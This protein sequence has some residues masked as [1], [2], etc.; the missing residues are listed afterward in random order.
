VSTFSSI[1]TIRH[2]MRRLVAINAS[3]VGT[4]PTGLGV[5]AIQLTRAL[6][7]I[8]DD[9]AVITSDPEPFS[10]LRARIIGIPKFV[11]PE[12]G[13]RGHLARITFAQTLWSFIA[14]ARHLA[15][16]VHTVPEAALWTR[17]PQ[18]TMIHDVLPL[19]F[20]SEYPRQQHYFRYLVPRALSASHAVAALSHT[21]RDA[22]MK[23]FG[24]AAGKISVV[25]P[26]YD[27]AAFYPDPASRNHDP[28]VL[29]VGNLLPHKN[30]LRLVD[31]FAILLR[32]MSCR[33]VIRGDGRPAHLAA[34]VERI[35]SLG[36]V[37]SVEVVPYGR[38]SWLRRLYSDAACLVLPSLAEGFGLT[39]LEAMAC[40]TPVITSTA[41]ALAE[42]VGDAA[43]QIPA[44]D[45]KALAEAMYRV[46]NDKT[47]VHDLRQRGLKRAKQFSWQQTA[48]AVSALI[49]RALIPPRW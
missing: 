3:I 48:E 28:Y 23:R 16:I 2:P 39:A 15:A 40:G 25:Y 43:L 4:N 38:A 17:I 19:M 45:S 8:R 6:D 26:G 49:D 36:I 7:A 14:G 47:L 44:N 41:R 20:P 24:I 27:D 10:S 9:I 35:E 1:G 13:A 46:L 33:L 22:V 31:A 42:V 30:V 18:I 34:I 29:F 21:T 11:R 32:R 37:K 5:Y 12:R